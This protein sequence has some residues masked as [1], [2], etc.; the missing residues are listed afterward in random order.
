LGICCNLKSLCP[1]TQYSQSLESSEQKTIHKH[2]NE[3]QYLKNIRARFW[4]SRDISRKSNSIVKEV[5]GPKAQFVVVQEKHS[6]Y[7]VEKMT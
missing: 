4:S 7:D 3:E 5:V 2:T 1:G 6:S